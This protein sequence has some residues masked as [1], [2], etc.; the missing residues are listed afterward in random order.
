MKIGRAIFFQKNTETEK[1]T[2]R[3]GARAVMASFYAS[4]QPRPSQGDQQQRDAKRE[5][6]LEALLAAADSRLDVALPDEIVLHTAANGAQAMLRE[7]PVDAG[8]L[9]NAWAA[10]PSEIHTVCT[11]KGKVHAHLQVAAIARLASGKEFLAVIREILKPL[12][13]DGPYRVLDVELVASRDNPSPFH[14]DAMTGR[15]VFKRDEAQPKAGWRV[16]IDL[17][18]YGGAHESRTMAFKIGDEI[19]HASPSRMVAMNS[20]AA[21]SGRVGPVHHGRMGDGITASVDIGLPTRDRAGTPFSA[22]RACFAFFGTTMSYL[23][24]GIHAIGLDRLDG[25]HGRGTTL[26]TRLDSVALTVAAMTAADEVVAAVIPPAEVDEN[27]VDHAAQEAALACLQGVGT[28]GSDAA[29]CDLIDTVLARVL[30]PLS[31]YH[32]CACLAHMSTG[33]RWRWLP[34]EA[35]PRRICSGCYAA[36]GRH[37]PLDV[38]CQTPACQRCNQQVTIEVDTDGHSVAVPTDQKRGRG[39]PKKQASA[40]AEAVDDAAEQ[41]PMGVLCQV[42][43]A[44]NHPSVVDEGGTSKKRRLCPP[45][46]AAAAAAA[47]SQ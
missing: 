16:L 2:N 11:D 25:H 28:Y 6:N 4:G 33:D 13:H 31:P 40:A 39:R 7:G 41:V 9:A 38:I 23:R 1:L 5:A 43:D 34:A 47:A 24:H 3:V 8:L 46:A 35:G 22:S 37:E 42:V 30:D 15:G 29:M 21:G 14:Q 18:E 19:V 45:S 17:G 26:L 44:D 20:M 10:M 32:C 27:E 12:I 36:K